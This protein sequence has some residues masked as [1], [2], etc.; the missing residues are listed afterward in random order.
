MPANL[1]RLHP[2]AKEALR[3]LQAP[4]DPDLYQELIALFIAT[5]NDFLSSLNSS[6]TNPK[7]LKDTA[8]SWKSSAAAVGAQILSD[9]CAQLEKNPNPPNASVL[10]QK[11]AEEYRAVQAELNKEIAA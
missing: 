7:Q 6:L 9:L 8:H 10:L 3:S 4:G 5:S 1:L 2:D 11:I